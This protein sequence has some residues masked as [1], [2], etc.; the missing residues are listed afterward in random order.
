MSTARQ[1]AAVVVLVL[2]GACG[3]GNAAAPAAPAAASAPKAAAPTL[4][5]ERERLLRDL[6]ARANQ[7]GALEAEVTDSAMPAAG[8]IRDAF[9]NRF[10]PL[11][12]NVTVN[13]S[14]GQQPQIWANMQSTVA[15]GGT[16]T[17]DAMLGQDDT[18]V[19]PRL[20]DGMLQPI[21][22]WQEVLAAIDPAVADGTV[23]PEQR[24]PDPL[25]GYGIHFDD[26]L[27]IILFNPEVMPKDQ[28][29]RTYLDLTDPKYKGKF[30]VPP[31]ATT[32]NMGALIYGKDRW[33]DA[34]TEIGQNASGVATYAQG[35]Q[36]LL[37]RQI[38]F[39]QDNLGDYFTQKSLGANVPVDYAWFADYT[40]LNRQYYVIPQRARHPAA[41]TLFAMY[42]A[43]DEGR[44]AWAPAYIA[45]NVQ[46]GHLAMDDQIRQSIADSG[47]KVVDYF[48]TPEGRAMVEWFG[49]PEGDAYVDRLTKALSRRG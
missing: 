29:P 21:E 37:S 8:A 40:W 4:T 46:A 23:K 36:Q 22:N 5:P 3:P 31:W 27:K 26:R 49:T 11:G 9:V 44:A 15:A 17:F 2:I 33:L 28:L 43:T 30:A 35:A 12:L 6:V 20:K 14:A 39:Q 32:Y 45:V 34:V 41:A 48:S 25:T 38:A 10:A 24:S 1:I 16:P 19:L 42:M 47:T 18:E 7:E 13:V